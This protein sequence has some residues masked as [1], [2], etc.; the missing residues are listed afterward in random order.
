MNKIGSRDIKGGVQ[1]ALK[2]RSFRSCVGRSFISEAKR[3]ATSISKCS[4]ANVTSRPAKAI[5][6]LADSCN[7]EDVNRGKF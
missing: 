3:P 7:V 1:A 5:R 4:I 6:P 2:P